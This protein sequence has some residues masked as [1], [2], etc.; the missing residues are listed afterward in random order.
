MDLTHAAVAFG[1]AFLAGAINSVAGGGTLVS[2]P[3][4]IW[5][6]L[7]SVTANATS[8]VA[9][10]PGTLGSAWGY[11]RELR[12]A[13]PRF[14]ILIVPS[15]VGGIA[16]ALL[17]RWTPPAFFDKLVPYLILFA[18]LLFMA[19][20]PVQKMLNTADGAR[21][22]S[23]RWI[24]GALLFQLAVGIYG[25]YFGAGI[26]ILM[27]ASLGFIGLSNIHEMNTLKTILAS[28][29]NLVAAVWFI[30][31]GLVHWPKA[32]VMTAGALLGYFLGSHYSQRIPHQ[33]VRQLITVIGF[34]ISAVT[35]YKE[36]VH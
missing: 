15:L 19:Q 2:F 34:L 23:T 35:F 25:G 20:E 22:E 33:R 17:L 10:W 31:A 13:E 27:L 29:I 12:D 16:G 36:F 14:R 26:G 28:L 3:V 6:G 7:S 11:R 5:L 18:T 4:L 24:V 30:L 32:G 21:H 9:I 1:A 8:T